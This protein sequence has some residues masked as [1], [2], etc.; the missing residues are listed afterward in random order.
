[1]SELLAV[2]QCLRIAYWAHFA[3]APTWMTCPLLLSPLH[4][5]AFQLWL[6]NSCLCIVCCVSDPRLGA[7]E[8]EQSCP[9]VFHVLKLWSHYSGRGEPSQ[10]KPCKPDLFTVLTFPKKGANYTCSVGSN[11][12]HSRGP[13]VCGQHQCFFT[14][15]TFLSLLENSLKAGLVVFTLFPVL[16]SCPML[17]ILR[18][19]WMNKN[20]LYL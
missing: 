1:M 18:F 15:V 11:L 10:W 16:S 6:G 9:S 8:P 5:L 2:P 14:L 7:Q 12:T 13:A 20:N 17:S 3:L 19:G 4:T